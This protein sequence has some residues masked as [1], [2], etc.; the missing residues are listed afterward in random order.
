MESM[1]LASQAFVQEQIN[2]HGGDTHPLSGGLEYDSGAGLVILITKQAQD[3]EGLQWSE[4]Q[5]VLTGLWAYIVT[6]MRYRALSFEILDIEDDFQIGYG[7]IIK[8]DGASLSKRIAKREPQITSP[9]LPSSA[10]SIPERYNSSLAQ[11]L[12]GA[13]DW[14]IE[15][16][17]LTLKIVTRGPALDREA[18]RNLFLGVTK[19][20][21][22]AIT[23]K[24]KD[25]LLGSS[26]FHFGRLLM[27]EVINDPF[28]LTWEELGYVVLGL[29]DYMID[30]HN[31]R[32]N[33]FTIFQGNPKV[34]VAIG[35]VTRGLYQQNNVTVARRN[36]A[37]R[38]EVC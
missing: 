29:I 13:K 26:S 28:M 33:Y 15:D 35:K 31:N 30:Y 37:V 8:R 7:H 34:E 2:L 20:V 9:A 16:S 22:N 24:G 19:T 6:G 12:V 23:A 10:N 25:A 18:L 11:H 3:P 36:T 21:Q 32:E 38:D 5:D 4:L 1:L 14:P 17:D 27:L